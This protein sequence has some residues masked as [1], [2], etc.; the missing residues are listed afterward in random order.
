M[1]VMKASLISKPWSLH[2]NYETL[3]F[4]FLCICKKNSRLEKYF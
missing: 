3:D 2:I 4:D 1:A